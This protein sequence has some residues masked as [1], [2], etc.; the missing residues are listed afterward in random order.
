MA[1][2]PGTAGN[3][4]ITAVAGAINDSLTGLAGDDLLAGLGG[5]DT[6]DGGTGIDTVTYAASGA[7]TVNLLTNVNTGN[8]A[9]GDSLVGIENVIGSANNDN[10]TGD[11]NANFLYGAGGNDTMDGG[12]GNDTLQGGAGNDS[13]VGGTGID[14]A[15]YSTSAAAV[16]VSLA[17]GLGS[18]G[19]AATDTLSG[20]ENLV[21]S[22]FNDS[23]TGDANANVLYAARA[24]T[25]WTAAWAMTHWWA[26]RAATALLA[27][28]A[29]IWRIIP[30]RGLRSASTLRPT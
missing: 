7:V 22:A 8:D 4:T 1:N 17:T 16:T 3:D 13:L 25:R 24:M 10:I 21:G 28:P 20:I 18:G 27:T 6:I 12:A 14:T 23:L 9:Q 15:D 2:F 11:A 5:A 26:A 19:D 30:P 29:T